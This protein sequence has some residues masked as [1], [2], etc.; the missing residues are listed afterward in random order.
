[1]LGDTLIRWYK[2]NKRDLPWRNTT[3]PYHIWLS[4]IILQ[5]TRV[6]QGLP[7]YF[8]F[9]ESFPTIKEFALAPESKILKLWQGLGYY[10][11]ARNM[12]ATAKVIQENFKG[13]FPS[14]YND[15]KKLKGIGDYTAA[16]I[17]SFAFNL[18]FAVLDGNVYRF[19]SRY[20]GITTPINTPIAK[21]EFLRIA[22]SLIEVKNPALFNQA[23]MEFG[24]LQCKPR[25]PSCCDCVFSLTCFAAKRNMVS[26]FPVKI[27]SQKPRERFFNYLFIN[28]KN[29]FYIQKRA[30]N[31]IW[32]HLYELPL[33][34]TTI[35]IPIAT[36]LKHKKFKLLA[37]EAK[38]NIKEVYFKHQLTHQTIH[39]TF[40]RVEIKKQV[41][42]HLKRHFIQVN[43]E[44][45]PEYAFPRLIEKF[46]TG[47]YP[48]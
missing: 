31:D 38:M 27:K 28:Y 9:L 6:E 29:N 17:A 46:L 41:P 45:I 22:N 20:Y 26:A 3:D 39:A 42:A 11:R 43:S 1:M 33:I 32:K 23:I 7:Y 18:P 16:A 40:Y 48:E 5:Q 47:I 21:K 25:N 37:G 12:H 34:E 15:L 13:R 30:E 2:Q 24:A 4:E 19:L 14:D 36:L 35:N 44:D 8:R 10:S